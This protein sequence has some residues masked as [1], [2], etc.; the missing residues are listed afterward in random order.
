MASIPCKTTRIIVRIPFKP[1]TVV[2]GAKDWKNMADEEAPK[3]EDDRSRKTSSSLV[4][5]VLLKTG[6]LEKEDINS[7]VKK[8]SQKADEVKVYANLIMLLA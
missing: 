7:C 1:D 2:F 4:T 3:K 6:R 8:I 5:D